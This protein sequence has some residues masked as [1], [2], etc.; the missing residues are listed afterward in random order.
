VLDSAF[1]EASILYI[2][3]K[4]SKKSKREE[5]KIMGN[6]IK[7]KDVSDRYDITARTLRYY[8]DMG[9]L[10]S[11]RSEDYA[12]RM[13]DEEA[14]TRLEQ[15][16]ILRKLNISIKD[17]LRIFAAPGSEVVLEILGKKTQNI[18]DELA[19]LHELKEIIL[20]FMQK[21]RQ[22]DF[23]N[24]SDVK[25][26]YDKAKEIETHLASVD[27]IGKP[28]N[29]GRLIEITEKL[30]SKIPDVMIVKIPNFRAVTSGLCVWGEDFENFHEWR[31]SHNHLFK[32]VIFDCPDFLTGKEEKFEWFWAV[33]DEVSQADVYPYEIV[34]F[35]G[36]LYA[37]TVS[38]DG[39]GES[40]NKVRAK[41]TK[42]L[43]TTN[44]EE[45]TSRVKMGHII[46]YDEEIK[47]GLGYNQMN[48][49]EP[50][51]LREE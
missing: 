20:E 18:D 32:N 2:C 47:K 39:D 17:I 3:A 44:F 43:E 46:Y 51:K 22:L 9:L 15:I 21:I 38:M 29:I 6:L 28:S 27:Y 48:L 37:V 23:E 35:V 24:N 45:D 12:Y 42:W 14:I 11:T 40:H 49:Y 19:L 7:I 30:D 25:L 31:Q 4:N 16:L 50:I 34:E 36:G 41:V 5:I 1:G 8:E 26:L 33:G 13:Y 10:Q